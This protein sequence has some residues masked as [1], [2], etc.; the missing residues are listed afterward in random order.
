[1]KRFGT[2]NPQYFKESDLNI[3][4]NKRK[5]KRGKTKGRKEKRKEGMEGGREGRIKKNPVIL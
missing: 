4:I 5:R 2:F 3:F 1:M